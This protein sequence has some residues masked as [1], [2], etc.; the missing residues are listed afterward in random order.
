MAQLSSLGI[1]TAKQTLLTLL[2]P[3]RAR[4]YRT[5]L[6]WEEKTSSDYFTATRAEFS[7]VLRT[8]AQI[9]LVCLIISWQWLHDQVLSM[10]MT[11]LSW[12]YWLHK[13]TTAFGRYLPKCP[14]S[15]SPSLIEWI[16]ILFFSFT[17]LSSTRNWFWISQ[18]KFGTFFLN[19]LKTQLKKVNWHMH[20]LCKLSYIAKVNGNA[21]T[22][23][24]QRCW[25]IF[26]K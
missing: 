23:Y 12:S 6:P 1:V 25:L 21:A 14:G 22:F 17:S 13:M 16:D 20:N 9:C 26:Q 10:T 3:R 7:V 18:I 5:K 11:H 15:A 2:K 24:M 4:Y 8:F 19:P